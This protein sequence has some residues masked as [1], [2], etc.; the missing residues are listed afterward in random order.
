MDVM[1]VVGARDLVH[2]LAL[3]DE[4]SK[5]DA[6]KYN[7]A[8]ERFSVRGSGWLAPEQGTLSTRPLGAQVYI[9]DVSRGGVGLLTSESI[10]IG[11]T[12]RLACIND[13]VAV[14]SVPV[15]PRSCER[16]VGNL[17]LLGCAFVMEAGTLLALGVRPQDI[18]AAESRGSDDAGGAFLP[19]EAA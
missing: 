2:A 16:V 14:F 5:Q 9:R 6:V 1:E 13:G 19:V 7:R 4:R 10:E 8:Y 3:L 12:H 15:V 17:C 18:V 11:R